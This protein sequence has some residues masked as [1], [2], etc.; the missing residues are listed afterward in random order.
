M[1]FLVTLDQDEDGVWIVACPSMPGCVSQGE[2]REEAVESI[3][4]AIEGCLR[5]RSELGKPLV[6]EVDEVDY[7]DQEVVL[8][9][10]NPELMALLKER[11]Q[12]GPPLTLDE[13]KKSLGLD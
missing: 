4:D 1:R 3:K 11:S 9:R 8:I 6:I 2:T 7:L 5:V 10:H 12:D 13:V